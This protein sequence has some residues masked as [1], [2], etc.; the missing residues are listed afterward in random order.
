MG[1]RTQAGTICR[2]LLFRGTGELV[3]DGPSEAA[4]LDGVLLGWEVSDPS[5]NVLELNVGVVVP[6]L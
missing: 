4:P 5:D 1:E 2:C 6:G 3:E